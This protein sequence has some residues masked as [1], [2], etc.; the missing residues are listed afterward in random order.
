[1]RIRMA[2]KVLLPLLAP[3]F[4]PRHSV[5]PPTQG[6]FPPSVRLHDDSLVVTN[7]ET[8]ASLISCVRSSMHPV[9]SILHDH[10]DVVVADGVYM[11]A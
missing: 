9:T 3:D 2:Q 5:G 1:M 6:P 7:A 10:G 11:P 4:D 8:H